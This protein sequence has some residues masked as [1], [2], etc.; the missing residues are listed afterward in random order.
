MTVRKSLQEQSEQLFRDKCDENNYT[1]LY[2]D[3][4]QRTYSSKIYADYSKRPDFLLS[5][6][7]IGSIFFDVKAKKE[8]L[9]FEDVF[10]NDLK[11]QPP[12]AFWLTLEEIKLFKN[13]QHQT[14]ISVWFGVTPYHGQTVASEIY[15]YPVDKVEK[16]CPSKH[17]ADPSWK[18]V[19]IPKTCFS[20]A[21]ELAK[22]KC[23]DC[24]NE[25]CKEVDRYIELWEK[26]QL[27]KLRELNRQID[28]KMSNL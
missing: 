17:Y 6:E 1:Y 10:K 11:K 23:S 28:E 19:Q 9:F 4:T 25:Y 3:Q 18:Y 21:S 2:I 26:R 15:F 24:K 14:S 27:P 5:L 12:T 8:V 20:Y 22:N 13:L 16:F 7:C